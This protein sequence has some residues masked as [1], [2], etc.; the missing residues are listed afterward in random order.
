M[1]VRRFVAPDMRRALSLVRDEL[2]DDA[3]ILSNKSTA[4]GI[5][6]LASIDTS[7]WLPVLWL[8]V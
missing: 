2:G 6:V 7:L 5:E 1:N 3:F 4:D 8:P